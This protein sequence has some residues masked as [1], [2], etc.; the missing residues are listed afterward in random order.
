[1]LQ[2][3]GRQLLIG[4]SAA[5]IAGLAILGLGITLSIQ[6]GL[7]VD[8]WTVFHVG[9]SNVLGLRIGQI[10]QL[11]GIILVI[12]GS[13]LLKQRPGIG[14][15]VNMLAVGFFVDLFMGLPWTPAGSFGM[16]FLR[17]GSG[18]GMVGFGTGVYLS[19]NF[20]AGPRDGIMLGLA[21]LCG[22]PVG[23]VRSSMEVSVLLLGVLFGGPVGLGTVCSV[24][25]GPVVQWTLGTMRRYWEIHGYG[26]RQPA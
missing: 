19:T 13:L 23:P 3:A 5:L 20:G 9:L 2:L 21:R 16:G 25:I 1:M 18:I 14:T 6:S 12:V 7:G 24:G 4:R 26:Q 22:R 17:L 11:V 15:V 10:T 8:P